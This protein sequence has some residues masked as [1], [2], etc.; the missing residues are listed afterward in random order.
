MEDLGDVGTQFPIKR[1]RVYFNNASIGAGSYR[2]TKAIT[3]FLADVQNH[4]RRNYPNWCQ[5]ADDTAKSRAAQLIGADPSEIAW[6]PNTTQGIGIVANGLD[7]KA[8]DN[9]ITADIEYPSNVYPW[10][11]LRPR[12]VEVRF[13]EA[14]DGRVETAAIE[15]LV[16]GRTRLVSLSSVQFS[17]GFRLDLDGL[18]E[19]REKHGFLVHLDAIQHLGAVTIDVANH[20]VDFLSAGGHKWLLGPIGSGIFYCKNASLEHLR[21]AVVGYHTVDKPLDHGEFELVPR[22]GSGRFEEALVNFPGVYGFDAAL[23]T[24][25]ELGPDR[26]ESRILDLTSL[27]IEGLRSKGYAILSSTRV[28]E[29]SGIVSFRHPS[30]PAADIDRRLQSSG[31]DVAVRRNALRISP[32]FYN[33]SDEVER[34]LDAL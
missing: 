5:Y 4:G 19:L 33:D 8:G 30:L 1:E 26:V 15:A 7:W 14:H 22:A 6:V 28:R 21:P 29:R 32:S 27:A 25:L 11:N 9:V 13:V 12:G 23:Q 18:C 34:F 3:D 17:N 24:I 10:L 20:P 31:I 16:D 2:V